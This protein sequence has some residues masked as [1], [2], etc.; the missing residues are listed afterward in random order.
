M[1]TYPDIPL[2]RLTPLKEMD[3]KWDTFTV[4][5]LLEMGLSCVHEATLSLYIKHV[6]NGAVAE[7]FRG[8]ALFRTDIYNYS[9]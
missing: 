1:R 2:A 5:E 7:N 9:G 8:D 4:K 6:Y 3:V